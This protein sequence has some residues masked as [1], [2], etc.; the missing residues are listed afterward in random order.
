MPSVCLT[1]RLIVCGIILFAVELAVLPDAQA[2][3]SKGKLRWEPLSKVIDA[4]FAAISGYNA[5]AIITQTDIEPLWGKLAKAG[6]NVAALDRDQITKLVPTTKEFLVKQLR[7][8]NGRRFM[9]KVAVKYPLIYDRLDMLAHTSGG[10][11]P[12]VSGLIN[13][14]DAELTVKYMFS[15][16]GEL[17]W[18][19][20]MPERKNFDR[21]TGRIYTAEALKARLQQLFESST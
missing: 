7:T 3:P 17:S 9:R 18:A 16:G 6:W 2:L 8:S 13:A 5:G 19:A 1:R 11:R 14:P 21:P 4:H 12:A 20:M 15:D 10:G